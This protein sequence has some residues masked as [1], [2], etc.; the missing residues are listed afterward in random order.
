MNEKPKYPFV[1]CEDH[2]VE[3]LE[4]GYAVCSH[5]AKSTDALKDGVMVTMATETRLGMVLCVNCDMS[6]PPADELVLCC[7]HLM[8]ELKYI[9]E[10]EN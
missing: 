6:K 3:A 1:L 7:A 10:K 8:R 9:P 4:P 5:V 2:P